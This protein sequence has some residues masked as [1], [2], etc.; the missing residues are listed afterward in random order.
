M[1][2]EEKNVFIKIFCIIGAIIALI[3]VVCVIGF[4]YED[5]SYAEENKKKFDEIE[6]IVPSEMEKEED[7]FDPYYHYYN[8]S[9][10]CSLYFSAFEK[11][12]YDSKED[13]IKNFV[14]YRLG[15]EVSEIEEVEYNG[16]KMLYTSVKESDNTQTNYYY[17]VE[18]KNYYYKITFDLYDYS[19]GDREDIDTNFCY[20]YREKVL[21]SVSTKH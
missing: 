21:S 8:D 14:S 5:N 3:I 11:E 10:S 16:E 9:C 1:T 7:D 12:Y 20:N 2:V 13:I 4:N 17:V 15:D 18:S 6:Y 19:K